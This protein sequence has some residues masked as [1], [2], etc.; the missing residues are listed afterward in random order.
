MSIKVNMYMDKATV[1]EGGL[2]KEDAFDLIT[3]CE[4][5]AHTIR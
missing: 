2:H 1:G 5:K 3:K 4:K